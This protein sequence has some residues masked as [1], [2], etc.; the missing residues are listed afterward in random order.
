[1]R[2]GKPQEEGKPGTVYVVSVSGLK[3]Y[4]QV[5]REGTAVSFTY[6]QT[7]QLLDV[8]GRRLRYVAYDTAGKVRDEFV[9]EKPYQGQGKQF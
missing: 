3:M 5:K 1:M 8:C 4:G 7:Y 2:A 9:L 6:T